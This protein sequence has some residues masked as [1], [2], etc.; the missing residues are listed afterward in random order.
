MTRPALRPDLDSTGGESGGEDRGRRV[1]D[2]LRGGVSQK[3]VGGVS[4][5]IPP[6]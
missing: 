1:C 5:R 3:Q 4:Q 6:G 2:A